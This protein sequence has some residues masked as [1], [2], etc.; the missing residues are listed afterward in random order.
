MWLIDFKIKT[1]KKKKNT[2][3]TKTLLF[4]LLKKSI[5]KTE[6]SQTAKWILKEHTHTHKNLRATPALTAL[7]YYLKRPNQLKGGEG[8]S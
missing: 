8:N 7:T 1:A 4:S 5:C 2:P 3:H 6:L